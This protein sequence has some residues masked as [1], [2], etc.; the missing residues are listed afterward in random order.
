M[1]TLKIWHG[2]MRT[3]LALP[4]PD[5]EL[6]Q[7]LVKAFRTAPSKVIADEVSP[8]ALSALDGKEI[9]LDELNFLAKSLEQFTPY[10]QEQFFAAVQATQV[11]NLQALI[12]LSF[13]PLR[14]SRSRRWEMMARTQ[15][16]PL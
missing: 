5:S 11:S 9:N 7:N 12:N 13:K 15:H 8:Q 2:P 4:L 3:T 16:E 14:T 10:E 6:Q 1:I